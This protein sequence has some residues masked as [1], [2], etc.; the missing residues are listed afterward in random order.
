M[1]D[2]AAIVRLL[3]A[4]TL[5][6]GVLAQC[7]ALLD[8]SERLRL[9]RFVRRERRNQFIAGRVLA[10]RTLGAVLGVA[11]ETVRLVE[12]P[13]AAPALA[14]PEAGAAGFSI[15]HSGAWIACA[16]SAT[17][18]VGLDVEVVD[19]ARD[20]DALAAQAFDASQ[21]AWLAARPA[22]S[23]LGDF[24][25]AWSTLEARFKLGTAAAATFDL[26]RPGLSIVVCCEYELAAPPVVESDAL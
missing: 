12:R 22:A 13:G 9:A 23:R 10:R 26:S 18:R 11:P 19:P 25:R 15:S 20:I 14:V 16:A 4:R 7:T 21:Q 17:G 6:D 1:T 2:R 24:Y 5:D 8:E 3:D